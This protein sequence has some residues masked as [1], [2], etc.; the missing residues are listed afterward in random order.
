MARI[1]AV[2]LECDYHFVKPGEV[3][4]HT[5]RQA[6]A[7][8]AARMRSRFEFPKTQLANGKKTGLVC[9]DLFQD[10][11]GVRSLVN[12]DAHT[13]KPAAD[14]DG[15]RAEILRLGPKGHPWIV[16]PTAL[17]LQQVQSTGG[18]VWEAGDY[19]HQSGSV[20]ILPAV[21]ESGRRLIPVSVNHPL[22]G[23]KAP[24]VGIKSTL[25]FA[26]DCG[27]LIFKQVHDVPNGY[28][29]TAP[30][31]MESTVVNLQPL[32]DGLLLP[33]SIRHVTTGSG[34]TPLYFDHVV[35]VSSITVNEDVPES[36]FDFR[37]PK[38]IIVKDHTQPGGT[39]MHRWG[40]DD[41]P[42][43]TWVEEPPMWA[44]VVVG[45]QY[46]EYTRVLTGSVV[47]FALLCG[48]AWMLIRRQR[49]RQQTAVT[50]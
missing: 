33:V 36:A 10:S 19:L 49:R 30:V 18:D 7:R 14:S 13:G 50:S 28:G 3:P 2:A 25:Y 8:D 42:D 39:L 45:L 22:F 23:N 26:P 15:M 20:R 34:G 24:G 16:E 21:E 11:G 38:G 47:V 31:R 48:T 35:T 44:Y 40:A 41:A 37:Y 46:G 17:L 12:W 27:G 29:F 6:V 43:K 9:G 32:D 5:Y 4:E 1:K